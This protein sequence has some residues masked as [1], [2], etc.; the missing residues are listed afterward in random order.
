MNLFAAT[1]SSHRNQKMSRDSEMQSHQELISI[2]IGRAVAAILIAP[3]SPVIGQH[4]RI[5]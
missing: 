5:T 3:P 4:L 1:S 2:Q